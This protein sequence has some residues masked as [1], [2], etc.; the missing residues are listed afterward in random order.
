MNTWFMLW[1]VMF[2]PVSFGL[3]ALN[4]WIF[5]LAGWKH[6]LLCGIYGLIYGL[7][8]LLLL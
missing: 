6:F 8:V 7:S 2:V 5:K 3:S 4:V 1:F